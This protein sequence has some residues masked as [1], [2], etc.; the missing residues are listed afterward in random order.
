MSLNRALIF[1]KVPTGSLPV[2]GEDL[3]TEPVTQCDLNSAPANGILVQSLYASFDPYMRGRMRGAERKSYVPA[4][5][6][7]TPVDTFA[8]G[9]VLKTNNPAYQEGQLVIGELPIQ[10]YVAVEETSISRVRPLENPLG[11]E[12]V[13]VFLGPLGM[14]GLTAYSS[15]YKIG[16]P[17]R[18][19]TIFVSAASGAVGQLVGQLAKREGL[20]VIGSVG[21]DEKL[22]YILNELGFDAGFNYKREKPREALARLAPEGINIYYDNVGGDHLEAALDALNAFWTRGGVW[23]DFGRQWG[24][25]PG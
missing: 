9:K 3:A 4:Y 25:V 13:R 18:G 20:R 23:D 17:K 24:A 14:P 22:A 5:K 7:G 10:E 16:K 21:S 8:I 6:L 11:L 1:K 19:E 2:P 12:D 15:L